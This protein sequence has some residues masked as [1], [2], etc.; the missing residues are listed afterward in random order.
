MPLSQIAQAVQALSD[1]DQLCVLLSLAGLPAAPMLLLLVICAVCFM[2]CVPALQSFLWLLCLLSRTVTCL[3]R[4]S[5]L[6]AAV[7]LEYY[8]R[9][10]ARHMSAV[11]CLEQDSIL[12]GHFT[13]G[14]ADFVEGVRAL[15]ID[16]DDRPTWKHNTA[17]EVRASA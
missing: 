13:A 10:R 12:C 2:S 15:L 1:K 6:S 7:S 5:P 9:S 4:G 14:D 8:R 17:A 11:D 16:K 3:C